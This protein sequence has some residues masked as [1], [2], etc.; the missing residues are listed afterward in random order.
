SLR[1]CQAEPQ[2]EQQHNGT[3]G[4]KPCRGAVEMGKSVSTGQEPL[5]E[6]ASTAFSSAHSRSCPHSTRLPYLNAGTPHKPIS[7]SSSELCRAS[8]RQSSLPSQRWPSSQ[9]SPTRSRI[10]FR[11]EVRFTSRPSAQMPDA[12]ETRNSFSLPLLCAN[13]NSAMQRLMPSPSGSQILPN[14]RLYFSASRRAS[15]TM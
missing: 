5:G 1:G 14:G 7:A 6:P 8:S 2:T 3:H 11:W 10:F 15:R 12:A 4:G 9:F 13:R